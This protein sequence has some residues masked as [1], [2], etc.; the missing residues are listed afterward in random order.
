MNR[1]Q[2]FSIYRELVCVLPSSVE[3]SKHLFS[4]ATFIL[5]QNMFI[6]RKV[7]G[8]SCMRC[9]SAVALQ[10]CRSLRSAWADFD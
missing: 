4:S 8:S 7:N 1:F 2:C 3:T 5:P 10:A 9:R 6:G